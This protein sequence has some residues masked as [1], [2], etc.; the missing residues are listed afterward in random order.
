MS[1]ARQN[2]TKISE[3]RF[4]FADFCRVSSHFI[5]EKEDA[6][7][8]VEF[9]VALP[10]LIVFVVGIFD[11]SNAFTLKQKLTNIAR[12]T[13]RTIAAEPTSDLGSPTGPLPLSVSDAFY[14]IDNYLKQNNIDDCGLTTSKVSRPAGVLIWQ[15]SV[16][17]TSSSPC[18]ITIIVNRG[19]Y[20]PVPFLNQ[21]PGP[22]CTVHPNPGSVQMV[23]TCISIQ[24]A[25]PWRF[26]QA[27]SLLGRNMLLP[28]M[29]SAQAVNENEF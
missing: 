25:Y 10:L 8:I 23:A 9:A 13:A 20:L 26:G 3:V 28:Q 18:G 5:W 6:A 29:I 2:R 21:P 24:Y 19:Y 12:D 4:A 27:A 16:T 1:P 7:Q 17:A 11:F 14:V 15:F 22:N